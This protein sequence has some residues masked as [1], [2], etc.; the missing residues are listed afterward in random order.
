MIDILAAADMHWSWRLFG[1][2]H[3]LT[4]HFPIALITVAAVLEGWFLFRRKPAAQQASWICCWMGFA[5][6]VAA[7]V[8]GYAFADDS[9]PTAKAVL[10]LHERLGLV[11]CAIAA[12]TTGLAL[13]ARK[14]GGFG[15]PAIAFRSFLFLTALSTGVTAHF[16]G[17]MVYPNWIINDMPWDSEKE[18]PLQKSTEPTP[19][20]K[21][22]LPVAAGVDFKTQIA[23]IIKESCL[24]CH[25]PKKVKGKV[26]LD[27]K[28]DAFK[29]GLKPGKPD[30]STFFTLLLSADPDERM[31]S[32][33][34]PLPKEKIELIRKWIEQGAP[35]PDGFKI[36]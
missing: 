15:G 26:K 11:S 27:T 25:G 7:T 33:A 21:T 14:G 36:E 29:K 28:E 5:S 17:E 18:K 1:R 23:P 30:D 10:E 31:P 2:L 8:M 22:D 6:A 12:I 16:G 34:D 4:V 20:P 32:E 3:P 35:W 13:W 24:K 9:K 19:L